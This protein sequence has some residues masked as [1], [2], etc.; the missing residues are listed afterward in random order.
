[1]VIS[2]LHCTT[3]AAHSDLTFVSIFGLFASL[4]L[5]AVSSLCLHQ[6]M[7]TYLCVNV[8]SPITFRVIRIKK[9]HRAQDKSCSL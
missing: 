7:S 9:S 8:A 6:S 4:V 3:V 5:I 2:A 1:M